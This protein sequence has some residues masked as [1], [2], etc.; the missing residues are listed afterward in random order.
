[1]YRSSSLRLDLRSKL[2]VIWSNR[3]ITSKDVRREN[4]FRLLNGKDIIKQLHVMSENGLIKTGLDIN[5]GSIAT[6]LIGITIILP[7]LD[8]GET[9]G[10]L[11]NGI[12]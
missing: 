6:S 3:D 1:M 12:R 8:I 2:N 4:V 10:M 11:Q 5:A 9:G 7:M